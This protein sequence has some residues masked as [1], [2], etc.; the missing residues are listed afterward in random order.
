MTWKHITVYKDGTIV[1]HRNKFETET[2]R[3]GH[4]VEVKQ[5]WS[6]NGI[7]HI[8]RIRD[9]VPSTYYNDLHSDMENDSTNIIRD[10]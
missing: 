3:P 1:V 4:P 8:N 7:K 6:S 5:Q 9:S 10:R 2:Y